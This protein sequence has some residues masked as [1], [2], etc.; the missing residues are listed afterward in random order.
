MKISEDYEYATTEKE[1]EISFKTCLICFLDLLGST[2]AIEND[3]ILFFTSVYEIFNAAKEM[4]VEYGHL[5]KYDN[6]KMKAFS[7]NIIF[8]YELPEDNNYEKVCYA[9]QTMVSFV[10]IFQFL[11][12]NKR[13]LLRGGLT[14]GNVFFSDMFVWG[15]GL[16]EAYKMENNL[17]IYPRVLVNQKVLNLLIDHDGKIKYGIT[18]YCDN[19]AQCY[20]DFLSQV[21]QQDRPFLISHINGIINSLKEK[22]KNNIRVLQKIAWL[23]S[24]VVLFK[25]TNNITD[26]MIDKA[27][28]MFN[29]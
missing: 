20:I 27:I 29:Q 24:Y 10:S 2:E 1:E 7:D 17:A 25:K 16:V 8:V 26:D 18:V 13:I 5:L 23:E 4:C 21:N 14:V 3:E 9:V 12:L 28:E 19:D 15:K 22:Y 11:A 6:I